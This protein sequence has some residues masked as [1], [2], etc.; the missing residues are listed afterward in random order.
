MDVHIPKSHCTLIRIFDFKLEVHNQYHFYVHKE[1]LSKQ[2][3][4]M[5]I[6]ILFLDRQD[7]LICNL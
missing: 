2:F 6:Y 5:M 7:K 1:K 3:T 4:C